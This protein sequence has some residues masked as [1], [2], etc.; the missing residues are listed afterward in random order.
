MLCMYVCVCVALQAGVAIE[1]WTMSGGLF[2]DNVLVTRDAAK[3]SEF[4]QQTWKPRHAAQVAREEI[5]RARIARAQREE[6]YETGGLMGKV[7]YFVLEAMDVAVANP[8]PSLLT[9][10]VAFVSVIYLCCS[11]GGSDGQRRRRPT[12]RAP[13]T[14]LDSDGKTEGDGSGDAGA[15]AATATPESPVADDNDNDGD[16]DADEGEPDDDEEDEDESDDGGED[17]D[18]TDDDDGEG[19][20]DI[21]PPTA[22]PRVRKRTTRRIKRSGD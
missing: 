4:A 15:D 17:D 13:S 8:I 5:K 3:A 14:T 10:V 21:P 1:I 16:V 2:F 20:E 11:G 22:S 12:Y 18:D 9:I 6:A 7:N 19:D